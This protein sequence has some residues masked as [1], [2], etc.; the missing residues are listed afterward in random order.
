MAVTTQGNIEDALD[1]LPP[2]GQEVEFNAYKAQ[3]YAANPDTGKDAFTQILKRELVNKRLVTTEPGKHVVMLS[4]KGA[5]TVGESAN[6]QPAA[7]P[8]S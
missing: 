5:P 4:R 1:L 3:L 6:P 2:A 7:G 8:Q